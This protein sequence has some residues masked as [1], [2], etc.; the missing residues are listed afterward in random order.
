MN[1]QFEIEEIKDNDADTK[2]LYPTI[3]IVNNIDIKESE[4]IV[5]PDIVFIV[6]Y[7]D[8]A[9]HK[10]FFT[11]YMK[12]IL[13]KVDGLKIEIYFSH[14]CDKRSFNRGAMK[15]IGFLA[16]KLKYPNHYKNMSFVFN[17]I[18]TIPFNK[19][20]K[21]TTTPGVVSHYYGFRF[22][23]GG[24]VV[25]N[26]GD[27]EKINGF[28]CYWGWGIE[29]NII[30]QRCINHNIKIDRT[31]FYA[32]GRP[33]ILQLF[34]GIHRVISKSDPKKMREKT[35]IDGLSS[36]RNIKHEIEN[37][38][39]VLND[40]IF[41]DTD[42]ERL[43]VKYINITYFSTYLPYNGDDFHLFD[44][45]NKAKEMRNTHTMQKVLKDEHVDNKSNWSHI[46]KFVPPKTSIFSNINIHRQRPAV[47][48][49]RPV[50]QQRQRQTINMFGTRRR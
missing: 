30:Q 49:Q 12:H 47:A 20:F 40:N 9:H 21:Y 7:R 8:R 43:D 23:L 44:T 48:Q 31:D 14:Q 4:G 13:D 35:N 2:I 37:T 27:F 50:T 45:R 5:I 34:D 41:V 26:G 25:F 46:P 39:P 10:Y 32:L 11:K 38:S 15:N 42:P 29:D 18:D 17:D 22:A 3:P 1:I 33:E 28:P 16:M 36:I 6:P 19:I 24:I